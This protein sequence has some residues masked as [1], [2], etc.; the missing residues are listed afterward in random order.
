MSKLE[1]F[2]GIEYDCF[3]SF[4]IILMVHETG[5]LF[6]VIYIERIVFESPS[7]LFSSGRYGLLDQQLLISGQ[8]M[9]VCLILGV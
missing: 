4:E 8:K 3:F 2:K 5:N 6:F 7:E 9:E 1:S